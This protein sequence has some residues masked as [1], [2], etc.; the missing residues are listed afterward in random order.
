MM[1]IKQSVYSL[2]HSK[3]MGKLKTQ[4]PIY[5]IMDNWENILNLYM[6][7]IYY[8]YVNDAGYRFVQYKD[9]VFLK[10]NRLYASKI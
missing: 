6:L 4:S 7:V 1:I 3:V 10:L 2:S 8:S 9:C 5:C